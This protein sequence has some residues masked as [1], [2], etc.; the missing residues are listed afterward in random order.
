MV[1]SMSAAAAAPDE[2]PSLVLQSLEK[3]E[4]EANQARLDV[5]AARRRVEKFTAYT[6]R[7]AEEEACLMEAEIQSGAATMKR[8]RDEAHDCS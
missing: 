5:V 2:K 8:W 6:Q 7:L 1:A 3:A 4:R